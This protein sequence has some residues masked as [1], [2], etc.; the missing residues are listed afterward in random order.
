MLGVI[1]LLNFGVFLFVAM[2]IGGDAINGKIEEGRYYLANHGVLT[3]VSHRMFVYSYIHVL[4][5]LVTHSLFVINALVGYF[6]RNA[7]DD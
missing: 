3:E 6:A 4:S 1:A 5:V 2:N 7:K